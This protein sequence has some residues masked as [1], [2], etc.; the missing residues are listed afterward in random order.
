MVQPTGPTRIWFKQQHSQ[1]LHSEKTRTSSMGRLVTLATTS[2]DERPCTV[3]WP[4]LVQKLLLQMTKVE[5][6][7]DKVF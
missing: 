4:V 2:P 3:F 1:A 5:T 6:Q 7:M